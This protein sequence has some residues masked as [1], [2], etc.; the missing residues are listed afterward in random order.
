[1]KRPKPKFPV[2][3]VVYLDGDRKEKFVVVRIESWDF[4]S[5]QY[6]LVMPD[7]LRTG[8]WF[9]YEEELK[10]SRETP[11]YAAT[12]W[13]R[14]DGMRDFE[15]VVL[16]KGYKRIVAAGCRVFGSIEAA[17]AHWGPNSKYY[18]EV[19]GPN[20]SEYRVNLNAKSLKIVAKLN[21]EVSVK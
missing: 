18:R 17:E 21:E 14:P 2:G 12:K 6:R 4:P 15:F 8:N 9:F 11:W 5:W 20:I 7:D 19:F 13:R 3:S 10:L 16:G 1:M